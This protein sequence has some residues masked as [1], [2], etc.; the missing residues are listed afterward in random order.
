MDSWSRNWAPI[1]SELE[2]AVPVLLLSKI[3]WL[4]AIFIIM[5]KLFISDLF[6]FTKNYDSGDLYEKDGD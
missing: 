2:L 3:D 5:L 4:V 6:K 1:E